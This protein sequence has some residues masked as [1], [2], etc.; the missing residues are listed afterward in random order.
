MSDCTTTAYF[1]VTTPSLQELDTIN[2]KSYH[3]CQLKH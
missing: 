2:H 1:M 3:N